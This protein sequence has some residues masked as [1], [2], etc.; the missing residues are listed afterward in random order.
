MITITAR[1][2]RANGENRNQRQFREEG[3]PIDESAPTQ[4][5]MSVAAGECVLLM[6]H[7]ACVRD[8][9]RRR[10]NRPDGQSNRAGRRSNTKASKSCRDSS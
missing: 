2:R 1:E 3:R 8:A 6:L 5:G 10:L 4:S 9:L 7:R